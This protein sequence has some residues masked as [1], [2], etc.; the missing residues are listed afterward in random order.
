MT[1]KLRVAVCSTQL[2]FSNLPLN[3]VTPQYAYYV[4]TFCYEPAAFSLIENAIFLLIICINE[5][6]NCDHESS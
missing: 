6:F 1:I 4:Y 5:A 2:V 3:S